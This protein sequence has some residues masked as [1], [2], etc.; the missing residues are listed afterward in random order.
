MQSFADSVQSQ[1]A[2]VNDEWR[3]NEDIPYIYSRESRHKNTSQREVTIYN[4]RS[5]HER[6]LLD[7]DHEGYVLVDHH[8]SFADFHSKELVL[9]TYFPEMRE[10]LLDVT[11]AEEALPFPFYQV[12]SKD[13]EHFFDAYSLYMHCDYS[14][15]SCIPFAQSVIKHSDSTTAFAAQD[16]DF[17][18]YNLWRPVDNPVE[19]DPLV[20][21]DASTVQPDDIID[22]RPVKDADQGVAA[23][24]LFN[25]DQKLNYLPGMQTDEV[26]ILKQLDSRAGKSQVCPHTSFVDPTAPTDARAR[27][28]IDVRFL[29]IFPKGKAPD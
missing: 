11:G 17:A 14:P 16:W 3:D 12:R 22:Y 5:A 23:V 29:C 28:S 1:V 20:W 24:P 2:Y 9:S 21:I 10:L 26:L 18:F 6:G 27:Q 8:S 7:L 19:R 4:A 25:Q 13:P 15:S